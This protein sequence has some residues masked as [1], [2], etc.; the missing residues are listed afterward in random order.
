V[1]THGIRAVE[2][3]ID[4]TDMLTRT[5]YRCAVGLMIKTDKVSEQGCNLVREGELLPVGLFMPLT[6]ERKSR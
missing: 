3:A 5:P 2:P 6:L 1:D 4:V